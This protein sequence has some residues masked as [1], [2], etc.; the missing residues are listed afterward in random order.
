MNLP[1]KFLA[2]AVQMLATP[3][4]A[5]N[6]KEA[7]AKVREAAAR[8]AK[9]VALPEVFNWR[10]RQEEERTYAEPVP[11]P[12]ANVMARLARELGIYLLAGSFLEEIP[13]SNKAYNTSLFFDPQGKLL[14][15]Y[16]KIHLFDVSL[17]RGVSTKESATRQFGE[18]TIVAETE[19]CPMGLTICYDVRFPEL[20]R[21]LVAK[22]AQVVF[23]P[24]AFTALTGEAHWEPLLRARAIENQV[25]IIAPDQTGKNPQSFATYGNSMIVDPWGRV[26]A[27]SPDMPS[28]IMAEID[29]SYLAQVRAELPALSHRKL[30]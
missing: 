23:V 5:Q 10:G 1:M 26:L 30:F 16:R 14:A 13:E 15:R 8:G 20:Y 19:F 21:V 29:L 2:A 12:T 9:I 28:V 24:S 11:G 3:D 18:E 27:R 7:E 17:E 4:K 25:Y 22:G 6:L